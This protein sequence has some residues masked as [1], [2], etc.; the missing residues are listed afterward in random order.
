MDR[1]GVAKIS[2]S[3][4]VCTRNHNNQAFKIL[5]IIRRVLAIHLSTRRRYAAGAVRTRVG[6]PARS[7]SSPPRLR[8]RCTPPRRT[9]TASSSA[10]PLVPWRVPCY[11]SAAAAAAAAAAAMVAAGEGEGEGAGRLRLGSGAP[12]TAAC[13]GWIGW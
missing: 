8:R 7:R 5:K 3:A 4:G 1:A 10:S 6:G 2:E 12:R 13:P 11:R 9:R